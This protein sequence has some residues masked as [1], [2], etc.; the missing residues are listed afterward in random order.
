MKVLEDNGFMAVDN[1]PIAL[2]DQLVALV[3]ETDQRNLAIALDARTTISTE[4]ISTLVQS[5]RPIWQSVF[6]RL[7]HR[8][9]G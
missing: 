2:I 4:A 6:C 1:M 5:A 9:P 8:Q 3:L 7:C